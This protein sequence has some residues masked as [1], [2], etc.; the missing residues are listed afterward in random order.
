MSLTVSAKDRTQ[1]RIGEPNELTT[2]RLEN[3]DQDKVLQFDSS[4]YQGNHLVIVRGNE[5]KSDGYEWVI[6]ENTCG[7]RFKQGRE[8]SEV[9]SGRRHL[10]G[11]SSVHRWFFVVP[12]AD[13][14]HIRGVACSVIFEMKNMRFADQPMNERET[15]SAK[16]LWVT[17]N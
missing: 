13:S 17:V 15:A 14:N 12:G 2:I 4:R 16:V 3:F 9:P 11:A 10:M 1:E 5:P 8:F 6:T 7:S